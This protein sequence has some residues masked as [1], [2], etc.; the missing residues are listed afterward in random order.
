[1]QTSGPRQWAGKK[2]RASAKA[3]RPNPTSDLMGFA[4]AVR[5][6]GSDS[7]RSLVVREDGTDQKIWDADDGAFLA[8][9]V[10]VQVDLIMKIPF[11]DTSRSFATPS[12]RLPSR[13]S[14]AASR[15]RHRPIS[16]WDRSEC[17]QIQWH[18]GQ[19]R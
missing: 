14:S 5:A 17:W 4:L 6:A 11:S 13:S 18:P 19:R 3:S 12:S 2:T 15:D 1:M 7:H 9:L 16:S 10:V 8:N